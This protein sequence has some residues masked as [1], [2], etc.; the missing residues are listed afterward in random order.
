MST[1][2]P[3]RPPGASAAR[4]TEAARAAQ[5]VQ[6][7]RALALMAM[8][9]VLP[10]SAQLAAGDKR[11]GRIAM[12]IFFCVLAFVLV[13]IAVAMLWRSELIT[14]LT[15]LSFLAFLRFALIVLALGWAYL[16]ID[17]W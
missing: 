11:V 6:L 15:S 8:T 4:P 2:A 17:A 1:L 16:I 7:R 5:R 3:P 14:L 10:G 13:L 12:R 9:L